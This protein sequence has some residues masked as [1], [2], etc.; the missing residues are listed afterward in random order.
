[1]RIEK[2]NFFA[3]QDVKNKYRY[4]GKEFI[5][6]FGI[7]LYDYGARWY[8]PRIGRFLGVDPL[9]D[10]YPNESPYIYAGNNPVANIDVDGGFKFPAAFIKKY[11]AFASY[12]KNNI[13]EVLKSDAIMNSLMNNGGF[14]RKTIANDLQWGNGP[15]IN[16]DKLGSENF[17]A[18]GHYDGKQRN[19]EFQI[20]LDSDMLNRFE[21][22]FA[23]TKLSD[24]IKEASLMGVI[25]TLFHE[26][27]HY[28]TGG[29]DY[30]T[31][32]GT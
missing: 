22:A 7:G 12:L 4:N 23:N 14:D 8:D 27:T 13:T 16:I 28:G 30:E 25:S 17:V 32:D 24:D 3:P 26:Y 1:M 31:E 2:G 5:E 18:A 6:D 10:K 15:T 21:K 9:A 19:G 29:A 20:T 11:P